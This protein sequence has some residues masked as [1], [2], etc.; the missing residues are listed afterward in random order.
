M[1]ALGNSHALSAWNPNFSPTVSPTMPRSS[2]PQYVCT[3]H[4][5]CLEGHFLLS[6][7]SELAQPFRLGQRPPGG[8]IWIWH[9]PRPCILPQKTSLAQNLWYCVLIA[10]FL[11]R[12]WALEGEEV[13]LP[14]SL[15]WVTGLDPGEAALSKGFEGRSEWGHIM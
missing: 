9:P 14:L 1:A 8:P 3:S 6:L 10:C 4:P 5:L 7:T 11:G 12:L 15:W 2:L 13:P